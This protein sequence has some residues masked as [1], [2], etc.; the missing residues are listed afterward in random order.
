MP[1]KKNRASQKLKT[2][3]TLKKRFRITASGLIKTGT[4]GMT[5]MKTKHSKRANVAGRKVK[6]LS[7][8]NRK[9]IKD[10]IPYGLS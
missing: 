9:K 10:I 4:T 8:S 2:K 7:K 3:S 5:H 6:Y 1:I